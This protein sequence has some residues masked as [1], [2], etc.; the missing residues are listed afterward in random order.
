MPIRNFILYVA[1]VLLVVVFS[2]PAD[3]A[4]GPRLDEA[5]FRPKAAEL[6]EPMKAKRW[7]EAVGRAD[8]VDRAFTTAHAGGPRVYC[9]HSPRESLLELSRPA[10]A[11]RDA[12]AI[13]SLWCEVLYMKAFALVEPGR[14]ADAARELDRAIEMAPY[15]TRYLNERAELLLRERRFEAALTMFRTAEE[16]APLTPNEDEAKV[17]KSRAC[18]SIG[19]A[20]IELGRLDEAERTCRRCLSLDP[21]DAESRGELEYIARQRAAKAK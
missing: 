15:H 20:L 11:G 5:A 12:V 2:A 21:N 17:A 16:N 6:V 14:P 13:G 19:F 10:V 1:L 9:S 4:P 3:G 8:E 7:S 18:R